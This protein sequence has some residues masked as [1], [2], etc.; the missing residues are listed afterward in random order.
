MICNVLPRRLLIDKR[1]ESD[2]ITVE[3]G[4]D[5]CII[6]ICFA[7]LVKVERRSIGQ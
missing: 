6:I 2:N 3:A 7:T 4:M 5:N 1:F